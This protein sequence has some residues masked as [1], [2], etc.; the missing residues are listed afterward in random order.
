M[1]L[2]VQR[3]VAVQREVRRERAAAADELRDVEEA[4]RAQEVPG[5]RPAGVEHR[6]ERPV[7]HAA[8]DGGQLA[9]PLELAALAREADRLG[10]GSTTVD[11]P[12]PLSP[13]SSVTGVERS[14]CSTRDR[15]YVE[16]KPLAPVH[17][18]RA[19][20]RA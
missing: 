12:V 10:D 8:R 4:L 15:R 17:P 11:L 2:L 3:D 19:R 20:T 6:L 9:E 14:T 1:G 7:E 16:R 18:R 5:A 13:A